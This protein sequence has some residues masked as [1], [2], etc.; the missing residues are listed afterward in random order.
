M[1]K[2]STKTLVIVESPAKARTIG[3]YLGKDFV[4][5]SSIGHIR[6]LPATA[7][8]IPA[9]YKSESWAR[10]G[11]NVDA[12]FEPVYVIPRGKHAQVRKLKSRLKEV[13]ELYLATDEDREGE[14]IAWHLVEV[15]QPRCPVRRMVFDEIT[16]TAISR[17]LQ[18]TR[19]IDERL[20]D[21]QETRRIL[22][23]LYG[24]E[25]SPVLWRKVRPKL[26]AGRVQSVAT[27]LIVDRERA[28]MR[29]RAATYWDLEAKL[30]ATGA[31]QAFDAKLAELGGR[32]VA[33]GKDFED[34]TGALKAGADVVHLQEAQARALAEVLGSAKFTVREVVE[35]PFTNR[36]YAP[37]ITST[38]QQEAGRKFRFTAQRTMRVAQSLY[39]NG[40]ITYMRTDSTTLSQQA[41][42]AARRQVE[43][44]YGREYLPETPRLYA[45]RSKNAQEAHEA[46]RPA[47]ES[48]RT[49][50]SVA[51]EISGD[52]LK[53]YDLIWKR[54][55]ACQMKDAHG[56]RTT[57][58]VDARAGEHGTA[59]F[60]ASGKVITFPGFWRAYVEGSDDPA[61]ELE[62][63][64]SILPPMKAGDVLTAKD[65]LPVEH[66]TQP[67]ARYT[68]ASLIRELEQ[69]GIGRPSTYATIIE[70][71]QDRGYVWRKST[72][73]V[74]TF[75]AFAVTQLLERH[76][77]DLVDY[78]FTAR[79]EDELD[80]IASGQRESTPWLHGFYF[81]EPGAK[82]ADH[83][84]DVGLKTL[85]TSSGEEV[86]ARGISS[87][88][89]GTTEDG[90]GVVVRV[91]RYGPYV[92]IGDSELRA[93]IPKETAPDEMTVARA[94]EL[95][96]DAEKGDQILGQDPATGQSVYIKSGRFGPYVQLG[97]PEL[98]DKGKIKRGGKP[99]MASLWPGM[100][101]ESVTLD[102]ALMLLSF[103]REVGKH[104]ETGEMITAQVGR[105]GPYLKMGDESRSLPDHDKL[106]TV[107][108]E[109]AL[110]ILKQPKGRQ[111]RAAQ[112]AVLQELGKHPQTQ[113][114]IAVMS[115]RYGA[116]VTDGTVN[117]TI[118]KGHDPAR[119]TL[120]EAVAWLAA[121]EERMRADGK[122]PRVSRVKRAGRGGSGRRDSR[123]GKH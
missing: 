34:T 37:F 106:R 72:A 70:T 21:A 74:P 17:A 43:E 122:N 84:A 95:V 8:E 5:E 111:R 118:P 119:V 14:A 91:G 76:L 42:Q 68:E 116:Y 75:T 78:E 107:T 82:N 94:L 48:F 123:T 11:V 38:L 27:R 55:V 92:Q 33:S 7:A 112:Q 12:G 53:L 77:P 87:I 105:F 6:D 23:R 73:L 35:K 96:A 80:A 86:D 28:R 31:R 10:L 99:K 88:P 46:I 102:D 4:V 32:R 85:V 2:R 40:Y 108:L 56:L 100:Q 62:D 65:V 44:L 110:E 52:E 71:I 49:P 58:K 41:L 57:V 90:R 16:R 93:T 19:E 18:N 59:T 113:V 26:S 45:S 54:T 36:P 103:P 3:R 66:T 97:D 114:T 109:D 79:M 29:F 61:A 60:T 121:R 15:L 64:E 117:A 1:A 120:E 13:D 22:D 89:I 104:P 24:Y 115:G 69:R 50:K 63:Q 101:V 83:M 81:G 98:D 47:G 9:Q 30:A 20:V 51:G 39:E 67:L 25:V